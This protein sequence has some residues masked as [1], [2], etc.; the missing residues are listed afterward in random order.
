MLLC[1]KKKGGDYKVQS[2]K[3]IRAALNRHF[4]ETRNLDIIAFGK[5]N[6]M[7]K[8]I[9]KKA[10]REGRGSTESFPTIPDQDMECL[11]EYFFQKIEDPTAQLS[12]K[13]LQESVMF[14]LMYFTCRCG[15]KNIHSMTLSS[16]EVKTD[17]NGMKYIIQSTDKLH[18]NHQWDSTTPA[19][20]AKM[21]EQPGKFHKQFKR[22]TVCKP[23][24]PHQKFC[25][26][27]FLFFFRS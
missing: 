11:G 19:N 4:K 21:Y 24:P 8:G 13:K 3:C 16:Y 17:E 20:E 10:R 12:L 18:K 25:S 6:E 9:T 14:F 1:K 7:F 23:P 2:L 15:H 5:T 26:S 22:K 27:N